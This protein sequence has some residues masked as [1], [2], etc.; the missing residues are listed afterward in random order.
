MCCSAATYSIG[1]C[2]SSC[3]HHIPCSSA[4]KTHPAKRSRRS[5]LFPTQTNPSLSM[6]KG[7]FLFLARKMHKF[8]VST[9]T[10]LYS[11]SL[12]ADPFL[13]PLALLLLARG[14]FM[15]VYPGS[16]STSPPRSAGLLK[17]RPPS[18]SPR[19]RGSVV[20]SRWSLTR[21]RHW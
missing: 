19:C 16:P 13:L 2:P 14:A 10:D 15:H 5:F 9:S 3:M 21:G 12:F 1:C 20:P 11:F 18:P 17:K 8:F 4:Q 6:G 7:L